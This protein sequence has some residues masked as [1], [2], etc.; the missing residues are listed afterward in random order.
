MQAKT[1]LSCY[2]EEYS[3][4]ENP[5]SRDFAGTE[6]AVCVCTGSSDTAWKTSEGW[7]ARAR[8]NSFGKQPGKL[9]RKCLSADAIAS[10]ARSAAVRSAA[11]RSAASRSRRCAFHSL[12]FLSRF[13]TVKN[14][15]FSLHGFPLPVLA[16]CGFPLRG[17]ALHGLELLPKTLHGARC[18]PCFKVLQQLPY[19]VAI[20]HC[21][22]QGFS[23]RPTFIFV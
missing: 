1:V 2:G 7:S 18:T 6:N 19:T 12:I 10:C 3:R 11:A 8:Q 5:A 15:S 13:Q 9:L 21:F 14:S 4:S 20:L 17:L 22:V 16:L 23:M